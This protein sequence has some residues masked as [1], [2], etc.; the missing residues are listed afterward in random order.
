L[1][2][3]GFLRLV[4]IN[5]D[6]GPLTYCDEDIYLQEVRRIL[7][8]GSI[9][10]NTN[11]AGVTNYYPLIWIL[12]AMEWLGLELSETNL[13]ITARLIYPFLL[14]MVTAVILVRICQLLTSNSLAWKLTLCFY[15]VSAYAVSQSQFLYPDS[16]TI[17]FGSLSTL[18]LLKSLRKTGNYRFKLI[19]VLALSVSTKYTLFPFA[20]TGFIVLAWLDSS[21]STNWLEVFYKALRNIILF[22]VCFVFLNYSLLLNPIDFIQD[23]TI[24]LAIYGSGYGF[25]NDALLFYFVSLLALPVGIAGLFLIPIS[26]IK[27]LNTLTRQDLMVICLPLFFM[28]MF[29][30]QGVKVYSRSINGFT[31]IIYVIL[32]IYLAEKVKGRHVL[33]R[34][35][36]RGFVLLLFFQSLYFVSQNVREDSRVAASRYIESKWQEGKLVGTNTACTRQHI[37]SPSYK[38][39][40]DAYLTSR[41][42]VYFLD[43]YWRNNLFY[44]NYSRT[45]WFLEFNPIYMTF[46]HDQ[47]YLKFPKF[48]DNFVDKDFSEATPKDYSFVVFRGY[49]PDV[50]VLE[51]R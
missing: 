44:E 14:S 7:G 26:F 51:K 41:L 28:L 5:K 48:T 2:F 47:P 40:Q 19:L 38:L 43:M 20:L 12:R 25:N 3:G 30:A 16:Y 31:G 42:D 13:I 29:L 23:F 10:I 24:N 4:R 8:S 35:S 17:F 49:G 27:V 1:L 36:V 6:I 9:E 18:Y 11:L 32:G 22:L 21:K 45:F 50:I 33:T 34:L 39:V 37:L 46:Y 15:F